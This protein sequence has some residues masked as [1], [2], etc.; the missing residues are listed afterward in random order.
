MRRTILPGL[1]TLACVAAACGDL[2]NE[3]V[4]PARQPGAP[5]ATRVADPQRY[6]VVV[7]GANDNNREMLMSH[8][9]ALGAGWVRLTFRWHEL[10]PDG[11]AFN[12]ALLDQYRATVASARGHNLRGC[13]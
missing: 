5:G 1:F 13:C 12:Q 2:A 6:G 10:Q 11:P 3:P 4:G 9:S 7:D 8:A